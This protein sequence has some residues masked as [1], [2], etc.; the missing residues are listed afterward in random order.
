M[1]DVYGEDCLTER[2]CQRWFARFR[3]E[4]INVQD[5]PYTDCPTTTDDDKIRMLIETNRHI[6][7]LAREI[8]EKLDILNSTVYLHLQQFRYVNKL[9]V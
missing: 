9:D 7:R 6:E 5:A 1:C 2:Q 8:A 3:S 4:N